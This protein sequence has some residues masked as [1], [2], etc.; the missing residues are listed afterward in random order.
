[1]SHEL[2][3]TYDLTGLGR[4]RNTLADTGR[5][6]A[7]FVRGEQTF[8]FSGDQYVRYTGPEYAFVDEGYPRSIA[9]SLADELAASSRCPRSSS[10]GSTPR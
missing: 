4:V 2:E 10:T 7:S 6:D 3:A 5:V 8:L 9:A 1:M